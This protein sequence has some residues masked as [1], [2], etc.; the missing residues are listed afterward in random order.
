MSPG[1][2][3]PPFRSSTVLVDVERLG[4]ATAVAS[5]AVLLAVLESKLGV[6]TVTLLVTLAA[7]AVS[8]TF[9][10]RVSVG[11]EA[12][13]FSVGACVQVTI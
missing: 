2:A 3:S 7:A 1:A 10:V 13:A 6:L 5:V 4:K 8:S 9:T 11:N 12:P